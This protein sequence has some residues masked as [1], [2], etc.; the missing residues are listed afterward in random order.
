MCIGGNKVKK[1][2][3]GTLLF[4]LVLVYPI[5]TMAG[6]DV[7]VSIGLPLPPPII[8]SAPPE[9][10]VMPETDV[11]VVPDLDVDIFFYNGW[12][13]R[14]WEGR[15][16]RSRNY[17]S[18]WAHY[19]HVPSFYPWIPPGWR[20]DYREHRWKGYNWNHQRIPHHTVQR[21]WRDWENKRHWEKQQNWGVQGLKPRIK[22]K[23]HYR[24]VRPQQHRPQSRKAAKPHRSRQQQGN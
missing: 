21:N 1:Y 10:I 5:P 22:S 2:F 8:F 11:Y 17:D 9:L 24:T 12:W 20:N 4:A 14:P 3:L 23:Q 6:V 18:G 16:Y 15:W 19:R 13:W 7:N